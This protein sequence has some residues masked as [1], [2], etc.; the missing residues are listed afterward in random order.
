MLV[1]IY[2]TFIL[3]H[4]SRRN[5]PN[6]GFKRRRY[7]KVPAAKVSVAKILAKNF[8]KQDISNKFENTQCS[9]LKHVS[10]NL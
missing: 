8:Y 9:G 3:R 2:N 7:G 4:L 10:K 5:N 6:T 1:E